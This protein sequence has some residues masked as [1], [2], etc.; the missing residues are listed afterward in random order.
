MIAGVSYNFCGK[1]QSHLCIIQDFT[2]E[3]KDVIR[4]ELSKIC[5]GPNRAGT[6]R[7]IYAY[8]A[9]LKEFLKRYN[10]K[11]PEMKIGMIGELLTH[12]L[13]FKYIPDIRPASPFFNMEEASIKKGFDII[14]IDKSDN[15][16]W[17]TEVKSGKI[18]SSVKDQKVRT[19]IDLAISDLKARLPDKDST[20]WISAIN[21][22]EVS[23]SS[24]DPEK[25]ILQDY[26]NEFWEDNQNSSN[27]LSKTNAILAPVL[28]ESINN[29][30][31]FSVVIDKNQKISKNP[32]FNRHI[33]FAIQKSTISKVENFLASEAM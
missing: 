31:G 6:N 29:P 12:I 27:V 19:L 22:V 8:Q 2:S 33:I 23:L 25:N 26:L 21:N 3:F 20:I 28:I 7:G 14:A 18:G 9:T 24:G 11:K 17:I 16:Y 10:D 4:H 1:T 5:H 15:S 13:L 30:V 32:P